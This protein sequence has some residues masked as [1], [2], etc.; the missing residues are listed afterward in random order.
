MILNAGYNNYWTA[1]GSLEVQK[2][3]L[4]G[5][6]LLGQDLVLSNMSSVEALDPNPRALPTDQVFD[7]I[8]FAIPADINGNRVYTQ[9]GQ[10]EWNSYVAYFCQDLDGVMTLF[11]QQMAIPTPT[12]AIPLPSADPDLAPVGATAASMAA[13]AS[14]K[15]VLRGVSNFDLVQESDVVSIELTGFF[16]QRGTFSITVRNRVFPRN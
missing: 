12:V 15:V 5:N 9:R 3:A 4:V 14:P 2:A 11:R 16:Q 13:L 1:A 8:I 6:R 10:I 7:S